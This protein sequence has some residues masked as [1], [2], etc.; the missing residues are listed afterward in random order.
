MARVRFVVRG[1]VQGV[2]FRAT[3]VREALRLAI[4]G[5]VWNT[6][7]GAVELIAEGSGGALASLQSWLN[8]GPPGAEVTEVERIELGGKPRYEGFKITWSAPKGD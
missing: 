3:A 8:E 4:T 7:D 2:N 5:L 6:P 1:E